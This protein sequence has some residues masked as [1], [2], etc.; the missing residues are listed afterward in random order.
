MCVRTAVIFVQVPNVTSTSFHKCDMILICIVVASLLS[1]CSSAGSWPASQHHI[2]PSPSLHLQSSSHYCE[3]WSIGCNWP[4]KHLVKMTM[5]EGYYSF[6][7]H[8]TESKMQLPSINAL[9][10][11]SQSIQVQTASRDTCL[12]DNI[13]QFI[14]IHLLAIIFGSEQQVDAYQMSVLPLWS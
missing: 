12:L 1:Y 9:T 3:W 5:S 2:P 6:R 10:T 7:V 4:W 11:T 13:Y 14:C 8:W